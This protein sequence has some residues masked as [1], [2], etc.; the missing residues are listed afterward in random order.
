MMKQTNVQDIYNLSPMQQ[1]ML[2][3]T[4]CA[5][6]SG[7][8]LQQF[9]WTLQGQIDAS[10][11]KQAWQ[12]VVNRHPILRTAF[13]WE[14][15]EQP[16]Q[17]V[18]D[19]VDLPW[20]E[21]DWCQLSQQS[22]REQLETF[23][24]VDQE[25]GFNLSEAPLIRL[26]WIRLSEDTSRMVWS[27]HH[28]LLDGWSL[29]LVF[30]E[31]LS[32][33]E[34][35][36]QN[37]ALNLKPPRPYRDYITWLQQQDL[38]Q[39]EA[40]WR[41]SLE[42]IDAPTSIRMHQFSDRLDN[43]QETYTKQQIQ[44]SE[45]T[46][47]MLKSL[48]QQ[49]QLTLNTLT[50]GAWALL[51]SYYSG[52]N[53]VIF[54]V[55]STGRPVD[56]KGVESMVGLFISTLPVRV[57]V[58]SQ[59]T[60]L[61]WLKKL[62]AQQLE[63]RRYEYS[64]LVQIQGWSEFPKNTSLFD[65]IVVFANTPVDKSLQEKDSSVKLLDVNIFEKTNYPLTLGISPGSEL[66]LEI[67]YERSQYSDATIK[68][69]LE[70]YKTLLENIAFNSEKH[71]ANLSILT[72]Q[73]QQKLLLEWNK[74]E[75]KY[76]KDRCIHTLFEVQAEASPNAI[77]VI[78]EGEQ[79]TYRELNTRA[80]QLA[81][82]L[83]SRGVKPEVL[84]G[85]YTEK[86]LELIVGVLGVLKA[87][88]TYVPLDPNYSQER[89]NFV[90][91]DTQTSILLT[92]QPLIGLLPNHQA[93]IICLDADWPQISQNS[94][95]NLLS[96][97]TPGNLA[98]VIYT[99]GSTGKPKGVMLT[100]NSLT[101]AYLA[102][103]EAYGLGPE[104]SCHL[105]MASFSFDVFAGDLVRS[106]CSGGT[107]VLCPRERLLEADK[108]YQLMCQTQVDCAEFVPAVLRNLIQYL[109]ESGQC[110]DF[111]QLLICGSDSWYGAEYQK[112]QK[113]CGAKTRLINSF[114]LTEATIDSSYFEAAVETLS[115]EKLV[116]IG[117]PF[118]NTQLY[119][120][121]SFLQ[122]VPIGM[123]GELYIGGSGVAR[124]YWNRPELTAERFI[125]NPFS[126]EPG[127]CL[128]KTGDHACWL[129]DGNIELLGRI[130]H[131]V[132]I[133]GF[134][135]EPGEIEAVIQQNLW[136]REVVVQ[137]REEHPGNKQLVAYI[138]L[139]PQTETAEI[140]D[141]GDE[142]ASQVTT[143]LRAFLKEKLPDYMRPSHFI[144]LD[145]LPLLPNGKVDRRRLPEADVV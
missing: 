71:L 38:S 116:P 110:L 63:M 17:V 23:L 102:W 31:V 44:L 112:F 95:D 136:V 90:L 88:G 87:G 143:Q 20:D 29:S 74:T 76:V 65:S 62:Q 6:K 27:Y 140:R 61:A 129:S 13:Y 85:I 89:L 105:Q 114:G 8:Y 60:L 19:Q 145:A 43:E 106:L 68:S 39:A 144:V 75:V 139:D 52:E 42:G 130:D 37:Q 132:K 47:S 107:L 121:N 40:F 57:K 11:L 115:V 142:L 35:L 22:Q 5:P 69:I 53:D 33:Y 7:V 92:Q 86:S 124:G 120:L 78:F 45:S 131:Q 28:L 100:H 49:H 126:T 14:N 4:L 82:Y 128:Y 50:Q 1:G 122:P 67:L 135:I 24:K 41:R 79:L 127:N 36:C 16:Y 138:V 81:H 134:R 96:E 141:S 18:Y 109:E 133:R 72:P 125:P 9:S 108:L 137:A 30:K 83:R 12:Q 55:T 21:Q 34:A 54:G 101:N 58:H 73:E 91:E 123:P 66:S 3:H 104:V 32:F 98:Y 117:Q 10:T 80:N 59:D 93:E 64:P 77:A 84:V 70:H 97:V 51:L 56:I 26:A 111:M 99:S 15:L 2:F 118:A 103:E 94:E 113:F 25:R 46:T 48:V 119:I